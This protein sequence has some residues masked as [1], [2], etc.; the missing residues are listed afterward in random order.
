MEVLGTLVEPRAPA[1]CGGFLHPV[2]CPSDPFPQQD[3]IVGPIGGHYLFLPL[4][5]YIQYRVV[6]KEIGFIESVE[7]IDIC[8]DI[9]T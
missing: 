7:S 8:M 6:V 9:I 3:V 2:G 4:F 5:Y 1:D